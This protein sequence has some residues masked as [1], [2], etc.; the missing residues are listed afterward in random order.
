MK[1]IILDTR[2]KINSGIGR[3]S[4][5]LVENLDEKA[6]KDTEIWYLANSKSIQDYKFQTDKVIFTDSNPFS[7]EEIFK[8]PYQ[9]AEQGFDFCINTQANCS[10]F[11]LIPSISMIHDLW[12]ILHMEWLP[13]SDEMKN[14]FELSDGLAIQTMSNWL[15]ENRARLSLT[16]YGFNKWK[17]SLKENNIVSRYAWSQ[18]ACVALLSSHICFVSDELQDSFMTLFKRKD[19][20][21]T[22]E[23]GIKI[24]WQQVRRKEKKY[25]LCLSKLEKRKN[26]NGLLDAYEVY[27]KSSTNVYPLII[28]GDP[29]YDEY[30]N[31][32]L[33]R[34]SQLNSEG[35]NVRFLA[36]VND[37][38][39][40]KLFE[41]AAAL[42]FP[43]HHEAYGLPPLEAMLA[44]VPVVCSKTGIVAERFK[45]YVTLLDKNTPQE[46]AE[47]MIKVSVDSHY[48]DN[49]ARVARQKATNFVLENNNIVLKQWNNLINDYL[50][51][52]YV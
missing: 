28:A 20:I 33:N 50:Y 3:V 27:A 17:T 31:T 25:F 42:L 5:W 36:S 30:A 21:L 38:E 49:L 41:E 51:E 22:I 32:I 13:S 7:L 46:L 39:L 19:N 11:H 37:K 35:F 26:I 15:T 48:F 52:K 18:C 44:G 47:I 6:F 14:R 29:G 40:F 8:V 43:T 34:T 23:N 1:K 12:A 10:P 9:V 4:Q 2:R 16:E 24:E 45:E